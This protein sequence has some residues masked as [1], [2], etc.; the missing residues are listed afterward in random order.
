MVEEEARK[1]SKRVGVFGDVSVNAMKEFLLGDRELALRETTEEEKEGAKR[2]EKARPC[3]ILFT[4]V[5]NHRQM[6]YS[7]KKC[8]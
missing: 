4:D 5:R 7:I 8:K 1:R 3:L 6:M 2:M